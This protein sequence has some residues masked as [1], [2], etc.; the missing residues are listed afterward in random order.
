M[1]TLCAASH[2]VKILEYCSMDP[3]QPSQL[4]GFESGLRYYLRSGNL[5][6]DTAGRLQTL[7]Q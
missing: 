7:S 5:R 6:F 2:D 1:L 3:F 4:Q